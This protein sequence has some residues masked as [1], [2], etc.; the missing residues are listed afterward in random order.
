MSNKWGDDCEPERRTREV[1]ALFSHGVVSSLFNLHD[2][3]WKESLS[4]NT[5]ITTSWSVPIL[6][7]QR[8]AVSFQYFWL[9]LQLKF[10]SLDAFTS[11]WG[12]TVHQLPL[13]G[14]T[15]KGW[16]SFINKSFPLHL[17]YCDFPK[18]VIIMNICQVI[19]IPFTWKRF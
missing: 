6:T 1:Y 17:S 19:Q 13:M 2:N 18:F 5:V 8:Q 12:R 4:H 16:M 14:H 15:K 10:P 3:G 9:Q 7:S 11:L